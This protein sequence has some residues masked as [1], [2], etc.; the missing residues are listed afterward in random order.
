[1]ALR[2]CQYQNKSCGCQNYL[3]D[4]NNPERCFYCSHLNAFHL[5][6]TSIENSNFGACQK[7]SAHCA[8]ICRYCDHFNA[9]HLSM[10]TSSSSSSSNNALNLL[11]TLSNSSVS[12]R[13]FMTPRE[14]VLS[15]FRPHITTPLN[16]NMNNA[17]RRNIRNNNQNN[18][19]SL[20]RGRP[21]DTTLRIN[22][23][24]LFENGSWIDQQLPREH[25]NKWRELN[26][27][28]HIATNVIFDIDTP[29]AINE[30][31]SEIFSL[32]VENNWIILNGS[33]S[34]LNVASSQV[35]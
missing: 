2:I 22:H 10:V 1:M 15:N 8:L 33:T 6:F 28:N 3:E 16:L 4:S 23:M 20:T 9:F 34:K 5:G 19:V 30:L 24:L 14:E 29:S 17:R 7:Y 18:A 25:S 11:S 31:V 12:D 13:Q 26:E 35:L 27:A 32:N 21:K